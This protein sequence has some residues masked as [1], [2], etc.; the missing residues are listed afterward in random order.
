MTE[1]LQVRAITRGELHAFAAFSSGA[2][3]SFA[4]AQPEAFEQWLAGYWIRGVSRPERCFVAEDRAPTGRFRGSVVYWGTREERSI[5]VEHVRLQWD[6]PDHEDVGRTLLQRSMASI[7]D[8]PDAVGP[9]DY[10]FTLLLSPP[11]DGREQ[12]RR[13]RLLHHAGFVLKRQGFRYRRRRGAAAARAS[14]RLT[15]KTVAE[16]GEDAWLAADARVR[17]GSLD[18]TIQPQ[19][20][21][22]RRSGRTPA[23]TS[24]QEEPFRRQLAYDSAGELVGLVESKLSGET[25]TVEWI[26]VVPEQRGRGYVHDVLARSI[27]SLE[28]AGAVAIHSDTHILNTPMQN[29]FTRAGFDTIGVRWWYEFDLAQ[30]SRRPRRGR[31]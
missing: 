12:R 10:V 5:S 11:L 3:Y 7:R 9:I 18:P 20:R 2:A 17:H 30:L 21:P 1:S 27:A 29:A 24:P 23:S 15:F 26:G 8:Q 6:D 31:P 4:P 22:H 13:D 28:A 14:G 16:V 25:G 19:P